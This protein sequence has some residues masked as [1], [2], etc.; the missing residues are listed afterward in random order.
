MTVRQSN[1]TM[2]RKHKVDIL[3]ERAKV[4]KR[5]STQKGN[6]F[7]VKQDCGLKIKPNGINFFPSWMTGQFLSPILTE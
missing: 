2:S 4:E 1:A 3:E 6:N 7:V 5:D